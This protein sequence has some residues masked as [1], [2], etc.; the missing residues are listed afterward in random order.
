MFAI[1]VEIENFLNRKAEE[2]AIT[3]SSHIRP[4]RW[5]GQVRHILG[6]PKFS[7]RTTVGG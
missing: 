7:F 2:E 1:S 3:S 6:W 5:K 4:I